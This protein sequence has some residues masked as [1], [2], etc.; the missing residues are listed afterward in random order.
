MKYFFAIIFLI[1][2]TP[3]RT[4]ILDGSKSYAE[5]GS[6]IVKYNWSGDA[7]FVNLNNVITQATAKKGTIIKL[8][9]TDSNGLSN[10]TTAIIK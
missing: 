1:S 5:N 9:V 8:T 6:K 3:T 10:D 2:C 4:I 7:T